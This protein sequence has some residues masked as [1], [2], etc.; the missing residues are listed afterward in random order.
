MLVP[1]MLALVIAFAWLLVDATQPGSGPGARAALAAVAGALGAT[2][3]G[4][5]QVRDLLTR[6]SEVRAFRAVIYV[7]PL[8]GAAFG[9]FLAAALT[10]GIAGIEL[11]SG[12]DGAAALA[13][14]G[15]VAGF[16]EPFALGIVQKVTGGTDDQKAAAEG[17]K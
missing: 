6:L 7:Q 16:S 8:V 3:S 2:L 4:L 1:V 11:P 12:E 10:A 14:F 5:F 9:L 13:V 15:F 17:E